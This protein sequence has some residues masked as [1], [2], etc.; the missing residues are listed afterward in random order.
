MKDTLAEELIAN[1]ISAA[2]RDP[3][4][5]PVGQ[6]DLP[7]LKY[8]VDVLSPPEPTTADKLDPLVYGVIVEDESGSRRGLLLPNLE[9]IETVTSQVETAARKAGIAPGDH[10]KLFRFRAERYAE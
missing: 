9:G 6:D 10:V 5:P 7:G 4:F 2:T 8:S 3:R 1:A